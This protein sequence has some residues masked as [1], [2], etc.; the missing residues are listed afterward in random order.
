MTGLV[1]LSRPLFSN[2]L[3]NKKYI[4]IDKSI[5]YN[6]LFRLW[7]NKE[8]ENVIEICALFSISVL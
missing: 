3:L 6:V 8:I 1:M 5:Q 7:I 2:I 4:N